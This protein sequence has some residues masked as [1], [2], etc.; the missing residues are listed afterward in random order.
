MFTLTNPEFSLYADVQ[1][2]DVGNIFSNRRAMLARWCY[3]MEKQMIEHNVRS[4]VYASFQQL[5]NLEAVFPRY[6]QIARTAPNVWLFGEPNAHFSGPQ[7]MHFVYL[8]ASDQLVREWFL[9]VNDPAFASALVAQ[10]IT[11]VGTQPA[12]R[13]YQ[14]IRTS[15]PLVVEHIQ[16]RLMTSIETLRVA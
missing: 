16:R 12:D 6:Q 11:P 5:S 1:K 8:A 15:H 14:G 9:V 13:M 3:T 4:E 7:N 10:E 2:L